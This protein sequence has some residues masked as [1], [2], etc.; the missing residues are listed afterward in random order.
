MP[1][2]GIHSPALNASI[3]G[4]HSGDDGL[5]LVLC[6]LK[7]LPR[8]QPRGEGGRQRQAFAGLGRNADMLSAD[9]RDGF[10]GGVKFHDFA[11]GA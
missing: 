10:F 9:A 5:W 11:I 1:K 2:I 3:I 8:A 7:N 6:L 4:I